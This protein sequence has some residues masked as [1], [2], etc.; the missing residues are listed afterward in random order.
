[1]IRAFVYIL[2]LFVLPTDL[3]D[4][5]KFWQQR[6]DL[7]DWIVKVEVVPQRDLQK[8]TLGDITVDATTR[9]AVLRVMREQDSDLSGRM[10]QAEQRFTIVHEMVHL[11]H[12][13]DR[14]PAWANEMTTNLEA[15]RLVH[16]HKRR[17]EMLAIEDRT[18]WK[19]PTPVRRSYAD[20]RPTVADP[21]S[22]GNE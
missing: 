22:S 11:R 6:M 7:Q 17:L 16:K 19:A 8:G 1:M 3:P 14:D 10:A 18:A 5:V 20:S 12:F 21:S 2:H 13:V 9:T 4:C 15:A